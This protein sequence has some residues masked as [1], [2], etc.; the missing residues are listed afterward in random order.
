MVNDNADKIKDELAAIEAERAKLAER[1]K[2]LTSKWLRMRAN[3]TRLEEETNAFHKA[4]DELEAREKK[5]K[6]RRLIGKP[7]GVKPIPGCSP[8]VAGK[9]GT[10]LEIRR[11]RC[12][13][14]FGDAGSWSFPIDRVTSAETVGDDDG[15]IMTIRE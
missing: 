11:T 6:L 1:Q 15:F 3:R 13:I 10:L 7:G 14:D 9:V 4:K 8:E 5:A 2:Q 12:Q